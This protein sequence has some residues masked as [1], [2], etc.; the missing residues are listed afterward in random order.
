MSLSILWGLLL[1][2]V[3]IVALI[4]LATMSTQRRV[5]MLQRMGHSQRAIAARLGV[6]RYRVRLALAR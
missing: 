3:L 5:R 4:D 1:P 6:T 2:L